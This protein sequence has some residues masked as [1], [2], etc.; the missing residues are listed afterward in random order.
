[1]RTRTAG[2]LYKLF[3]SEI[4]LLI[5]QTF[6]CL[7]LLVTN[8]QVTNLLPWLYYMYLVSQVFSN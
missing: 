6:V 1:M 2:Y 8:L 7:D 4:A 3:L 5:Y